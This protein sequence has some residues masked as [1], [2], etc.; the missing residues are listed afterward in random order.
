M[1]L[2]GAAFVE[3]FRELAADGKMNPGTA[4]LHR[5]AVRKM[6]ASQSG[7]RQAAVAEL[8]TEALFASLVEREG[9]ELK[10]A[11]LETYRNTYQRALEMFLEWGAVARDQRP[12]WVVSRRRSRRRGPPRGAPHAS[13]SFEHLLPLPNGRLAQLKLPADLTVTEARRLAAF[14]ETLAS[15]FEAPVP[16]RRS[17]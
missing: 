4:A 9:G 8:D 6:L 11:T 1:K 17:E 14:V 13:D 10:R 7:W 15:D 12:D 3:F 5:T 16:V 2:T